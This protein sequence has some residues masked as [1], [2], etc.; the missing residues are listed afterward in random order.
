V[1]GFA[2][3]R[4]AAGNVIGVRRILKIFQVTGHAGGTGQ[5]VIV[6]DVTVGT[7]PRRNRMRAGQ[8]EVHQRVIEGCGSPGER[9]VTLRAIRREVRGDVVGIGSSLKIFEVAGNAVGAVQVVII[10]DVAIDALP[11][12]DSVASRERESGGVVI[13]LGVQPIV[14]RVAGL[15]SGGE[16][17]LRVTVD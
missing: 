17:G 16:L 8:G 11:G 9:R 3:L 5:V 1:A 13:K 7:L 2:G 4:E 6:V 15:T 10:V 14:S 12:R